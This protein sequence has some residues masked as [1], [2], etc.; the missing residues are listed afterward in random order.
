MSVNVVVLSGR[1]GK[2]PELRATTTGKSVVQFSIAVDDGWGEKKRTDWW[3]IEAWDKTAEAVNKLVSAGKRVV[4]SGILKKDNWKDSKTGEAKSKTK[5][6][7]S[8]IEI[9]DFPEK[10]QA[11]GYSGSEDDIPF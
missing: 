1:L 4:V 10:E 3:D 2:D 6:L 8:R 11:D 5:I 7:A 9:I